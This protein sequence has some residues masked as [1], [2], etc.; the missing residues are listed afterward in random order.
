MGARLLLTRTSVPKAAVWVVGWLV[1]WL[2]VTETEL[3]QGRELGY[4]VEGGPGAA[5]LSFL[6]GCCCVSLAYV[7]LAVYCEVFVCPM[8]CD[9][10]RDYLNVVVIVGCGSRVINALRVRCSVVALICC[11]DP[12]S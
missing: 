9:F 5:V 6:S 12:S 1:G 8:L 7:R 10:F 2:A 3:E 11:C 4:R